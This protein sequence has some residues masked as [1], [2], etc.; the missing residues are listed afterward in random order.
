MPDKV[1][2]ILLL[3]NS[4]CAC[5]GNYYCSHL[6]KEMW[7]LRTRI[8]V[9]QHVGQKKPE[10]FR[11]RKQLL[12]CKQLSPQKASKFSRRFR[13]Q[14]RENQLSRVKTKIIITLLT[15]QWIKPSIVALQIEET[16]TNNNKSNPIFGFW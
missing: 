9:T 5:F 16:T 8:T 7:T 4:G 1:I 11:V 6:P 3:I 14:L 13:C 15:S 2:I 12:L 10:Y